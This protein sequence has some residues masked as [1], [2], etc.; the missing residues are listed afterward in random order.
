MVVAG[1]GLSLAFQAQFL[2]RADPRSQ[3]EP[4]TPVYTG[5]QLRFCFQTFQNDLA[6]LI[7]SDSSVEVVQFPDSV[8]GQ[9][10]GFD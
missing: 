1:F 5:K 8:G 6:A 9:T 3:T 7:G 10:H 2:A 4:R